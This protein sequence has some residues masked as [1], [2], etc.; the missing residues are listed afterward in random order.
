MLRTNE[1]TAF[2]MCEEWWHELLGHSEAVLVS[3]G[4]LTWVLNIYYL[5]LFACVLSAW[6]K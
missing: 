1:T 5:R 4:C 2:G 6:H 3:D